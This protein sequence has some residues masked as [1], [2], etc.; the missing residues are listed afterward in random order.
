MN[1]DYLALLACIQKATIPIAQMNDSNPIAF[2]VV[3]IVFEGMTELQQYSII[4]QMMQVHERL[5]AFEHNLPRAR[6]LMQLGKTSECR[7]LVIKELDRDRLDNQGILSDSIRGEFHELLSRCYEDKED[8]QLAKAQLRMALEQYLRFHQVCPED[9]DT[10]V[11]IGCIF[12]KLEEYKESLLWMKRVSHE[13]LSYAGNSQF[14]TSYGIVLNK[15]GMFYQSYY[16]LKLVLVRRNQRPAH[17][18]GLVYMVHNCYVLRKRK[19]FYRYSAMLQIYDPTQECFLREYLEK[20]G[21]RERLKVLFFYAQPPEDIQST[22]DMSTVSNQPTSKR[23]TQMVLGK[24]KVRFSI[25]LQNLSLGIGSPT[26]V[27]NSTLSSIRLGITALR[28]C[29]N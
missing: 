2:Q 19:H 29:L 23:I 11:S 13:N 28:K 24:K 5:L 14:N 4:D 20:K 12:A 10:W 16:R 15:S 22:S 8:R 1:C 7:D 21:D 17:P 6:I 3:K 9:V 18:E 25:D 27:L 26:T